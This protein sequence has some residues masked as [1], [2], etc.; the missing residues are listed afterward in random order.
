MSETVPGNIPVPFHTNN[1]NGTISGTD[2]TVFRTLT[3]PLLSKMYFCLESWSKKLKISFFDWQ[4]IIFLSI[5][6]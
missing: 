5:E 6:Q 2:R 4:N 1:K 3:S